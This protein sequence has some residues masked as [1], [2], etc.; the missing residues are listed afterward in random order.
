M[1]S[2]SRSWWPSWML[3]LLSTEVSFQKNDCFVKADICIY[4]YFVSNNGSFSI[5][6]IFRLGFKFLSG[7]LFLS[8]LPSFLPSFFG[9]FL[10]S[11]IVSNS[12]SLAATLIQVHIFYQ[13]L[14]LNQFVKSDFFI[15]IFIKHMQNFFHFYT[16]YRQCMDIAIKSLLCERIYSSKIQSDNKSITS[17]NYSWSLSYLSFL[18]CQIWFLVLIFYLMT[19]LKIK[20]NH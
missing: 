13:E 3:L 1:L 2:W 9:V 19:F 5:T 7:P 6:L 11:A 8:D 4:T 12:V 14:T 17:V 20:T 16:S 15:I 10:V 18:F